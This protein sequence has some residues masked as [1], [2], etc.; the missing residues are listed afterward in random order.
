MGRTLLG[1]TKRQEDIQLLSPEQQ[2]LFSQ[3]L[4]DVGP[5]ALQSL[6][7]SLQ[8]QG[9]EEL[10][11]MFQQTTID[12]ALQALQQ[13]ILPAI[14]QRFADANASSSSA[15]NQALAQTATDL[16]TSLG[17][18]FGQFAQGQ[19]QLQQGA[20]GQ[21]LPFLTQPTFQPVLEQKQ[22]ILGP[23]IGAAGQAASAYATGGLG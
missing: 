1:G 13:Q 10:M 8:P 3:G 16:S 15:L 21:A 17:S 23:L 14:Q 9:A 18:Q 12:P 2:Q 6:G 4:Q 11:S 19:Q 7:Q 22:G 20:R 5:Q